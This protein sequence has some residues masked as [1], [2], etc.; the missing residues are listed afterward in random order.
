MM[1]KN[2]QDAAFRAQ[3]LGRTQLATLY[4][5]NYTPEAAWR[6]L[7]EWIAYSPTLPR[8]LSDLGYT[9]RQRLF[10][11]AQVQAIVE[12]LGEP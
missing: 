4:L 9:G 12:E 1:Q 8:R 2:C 7:R 11:P 5:P 3:T 10:T 6:R